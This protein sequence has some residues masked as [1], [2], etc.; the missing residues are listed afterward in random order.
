MRRRKAA[1]C[2]DD[3]W[4]PATV[5]TRSIFLAGC[6]ARPAVGH[7]AAAPPSSVM[8]SRRF[9]R[10]PRRRGR[11]AWRNFEAK[12]P[13]GLQ[14]DHHLELGRELDRQIGRLLAL[15]NA[16]NIDCRSTVH[17]AQVYA[18]GDQTAIRGLKTKRVY[19]GQA[20][21]GCQRDDQITMNNGKAV[22]HHDHGTSWFA[23]QRGYSSFNLDAAVNG[24]LNCLYC[25]RGTSDLD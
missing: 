17:V 25:E 14:I 3:F 10:S 21:L 19:R 22:R 4:V 12:R 6:C 9:T 2:G 5:P 1:H 16:I 13:R 24:G 7:A 23:C 20:I 15:E 11:A 8:N 18:V